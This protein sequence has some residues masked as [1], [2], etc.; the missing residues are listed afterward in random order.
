MNNNYK[1]RDQSWY[2]NQIKSNFKGWNWK[3]KDLKQNI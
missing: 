1:N 3:K 2:K